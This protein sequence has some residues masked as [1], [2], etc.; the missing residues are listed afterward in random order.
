M[1]RCTGRRASSGLPPAD[2]T[3]E[4]TEGLL[5]ADTHVSLSKLAALKYLG[6]RL[7][8]DDFG[9]G[10]SS[11]SYLH[12]FPIDQ[13][14][15]DKSFVDNVAQYGDGSTLARAVIGL[16]E[17]LGIGTVGEGIETR[18]QVWMLVGLG[19]EL[20]QGYYFSRP[21]PAQE[22]QDLLRQKFQVAANP[23]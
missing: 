12:R 18:E 22:A 9:T 7:A 16:G 11:L 1:W 5:V 3:L 19:S 4:I 21:V 17:V 13:L 20:G 23:S 6:V 10:Y 2:L 8:I 15:I 14:K